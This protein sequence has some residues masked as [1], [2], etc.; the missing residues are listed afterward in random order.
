MF[1]VKFLAAVCISF[2]LSLAVK[3][4]SRTAPHHHALHV[5]SDNIPRA[6]SIHRHHESTP[7]DPTEELVTKQENADDQSTAGLSGVAHQLMKRSTATVDM[8]EK[9]NTVTVDWKSLMVT[10]SEIIRKLFEFVSTTF[11]KLKERLL[12][13]FVL[14]FFPSADRQGHPAVAAFTSV[15]WRSAATTVF[16]NLIKF[17]HLRKN[18]VW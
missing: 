14:P 9:R 15:D 3:I 16:N 6:S 18:E 13:A 1:T 2:L 7:D 12:H 17:Q 5:G 4:E 8:V 11:R 10:S